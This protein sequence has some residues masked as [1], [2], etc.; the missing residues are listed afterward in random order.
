[1][2]SNFTSFRPSP[3]AFKVMA[4]ANHLGIDPTLHVR[5]PAQGR[6]KDRRNT[7][8]SIPTCGCRRSRTAITCCGSRTP[9]C[10]ISPARS[11]RAGCC[12]TDETGRLDVTRWQFWDLAHWDPACASFIFENVVKSG[13]AQE[14]RARSG[15]ARQRD[16][17]FHRAA[18]VLDGQLKGKK[19]VTGDTLTLADFSLGAPINL[20]EMARFPLEPYG[21]IKRWYGSLRA[22]RHGRRR[23]RNAPCRPP[24]R[25]EFDPA[26]ANHRNFAPAVDP[27]PPTRSRTDGAAGYSP[28]GFRLGGHHTLAATTRVAMAYAARAQQ[29]SFFVELAFLLWSLRFG[30]SK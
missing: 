17:S 25:R 8:R 19:F 28:G 5:R 14:R 27:R 11:R 10:S 16:R 6:A 9:S 26:I 1:M 23:S 3:R 22:C 24:P 7:P 2:T 12:P 15:G 21:E 4:V 30:V 18:Q 29:Q 13:R 20:A